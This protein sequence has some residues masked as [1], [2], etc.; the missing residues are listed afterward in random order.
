VRLGDELLW[1]SFRDVFEVDGKKVRDGDARLERLF[2]HSDASGVERARKIMEESAA[3]NIGPVVRTINVPT[4]PLVFLHPQNQGRFVFE[5][6]GRRR[7]AG[8]LGVEVRLEEAG[9]P[10]FVRRE[11][12]ADLPAEG[13][14]WIDPGRGTVL[15]TEVRFDFA[16]M[17]ATA[18]VTTD[19]RPEPRLAMWGPSEMRERY[20]GS[21]ATARYSN[22]RRFGVSVEEK[23]RLP[24]TEKP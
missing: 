19:Y 11:W 18:T 12:G 9:R 6:K 15:R 10:T 20:P 1:G 8:V 17:R 7:I 23:V 5:R 22:F 4:L 2:R 16:P 3:Y 21:G 14:F 13:S 24:A